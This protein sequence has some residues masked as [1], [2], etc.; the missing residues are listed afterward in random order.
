MATEEQLR[1]YLKR[2]TVE[3]AQTRRWLTEAEDRRHEPIAIVGMACRYPGGG[4]TVDGFWE[5]LRDGKTAAIEVPPSRWN[6]DDYYNP[7]KGAVGGMYTRHG[8]F[9]PDITGWDAEFFG[10]SPREA[11]RMDPQQRLLMELAWE[12]LEDA[13]TPPARLAGSKTGVMV[14][15][16][17]TVQYARLQVERHGLAAIGDPFLGQ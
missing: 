2:A 11:L 7:D 1:S 9:L 4:D 6:I 17:D 16:M 14:G 3:L 15:F 5:L 12:G 13:G 10:I 8:A